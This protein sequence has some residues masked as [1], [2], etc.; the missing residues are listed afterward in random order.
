[1]T[2]KFVKLIIEIGTE[3]YLTLVFVD[4]CKLLLTDCKQFFTTIDKK[5]FNNC[6]L[7]KIIKIPL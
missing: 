4:V 7:L 1:M 6:Y 3:I 2:K 5:E